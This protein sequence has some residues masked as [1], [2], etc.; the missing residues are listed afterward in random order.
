MR[1]PELWAIPV[2]I[3]LFHAKPSEIGEWKKDYLKTMVSVRPIS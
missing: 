3:G 1:Q 2:K